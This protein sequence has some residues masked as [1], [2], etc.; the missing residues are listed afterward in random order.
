MWIS[1]ISVEIE[2]PTT[3]EI[4]QGV[5]NAGDVPQVFFPRNWK[6]WA[7]KLNESVRSEECISMDFSS[8]AM[9]GTVAIAFRHID[10]N[11]HVFTSLEKGE[12][13]GFIVN[14]ETLEKLH[15]AFGAAI[16]AARK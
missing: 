11:G 4:N 1:C 5:E 14:L 16:A 7:S 3:N 6:K 15:A 10:E 12:V 13:F 2:H 9:P 8:N